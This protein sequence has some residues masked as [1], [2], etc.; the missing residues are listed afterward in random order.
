[1]EHV[2]DAGQSMTVLAPEVPVRIKFSPINTPPT[3]QQ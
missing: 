3:K 2:V 1:M